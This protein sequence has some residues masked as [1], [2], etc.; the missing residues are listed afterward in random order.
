MIA[1]RTE[2]TLMFASIVVPVDTQ[3]PASWAAILPTAISMVQANQARLT[4]CTIIP[5]VR[6]MIEAEWSAIGY[7]QMVD[8]ARTR[9]A[10][11]AEQFP[12]IADA[13]IEVGSGSIWRG[14]VEIASQAKADLIILASHR[15][16][17]KDY[18]SRRQCCERGPACAVL[19]NGGP[20]LTLSD[21]AEPGQD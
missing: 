12:G 21:D 5:D 1:A 15:P 14:I 13:Q 6:A 9:L 3:E 8:I 18:L 4:L 20:L 17:M 2:G 10:T 16:E 7:R 19:R 11:L